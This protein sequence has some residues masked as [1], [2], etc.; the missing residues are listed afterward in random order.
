VDLG[1]RSLARLVAVGALCA[2][3]ATASAQPAPSPTPAAGAP[4]TVDGYCYW[5]EGVAASA[6]D[7]LYAPS[8][9]GSVGYVK[10][11]NLATGSDAVDAGVRVQAGLQYKLSGIYEASLT[12]DRA[13]HDC[14]RHKALDRVQGETTYRALEARVRTLDAALPEADKIL[15]Q[16]AGDVEGRRATAQDLVA[17]RLRV[18]ELR[19]LAGD[20]RRAI[21]ALPAPNP[22]NGKLGGALGDYYTHD[23]EIEKAEG[24]LRMMQGIDV[25]VRVGYD[26]FLDRSDNSPIFGLLQ[27]SF[28]LGILAQGGANDRALA[29]RRYMVR[30]QHQVQLVDTTI[31]HLRELVD[32][33][34]KRVE[35]TQVLMNDLEKQMAVLDKIGGDDN[36]RY[37]QTVWFD[38][39]KVQADNAYYVAHVAVLKQV[40]GE[41]AP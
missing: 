28:N 29:G 41:V 30:E 19:G 12:R 17:M 16:I 37:R 20:A 22:N 11:P 24:T 23:E 6:S 27:V 2:S 36:R 34:S 7:V 14:M 35:E 38:Y 4:S 8:V 10:E 1:Y 18:N 21:D 9:F 33:E 3:S 15:T 39:V 13:H 40:I 32:S 31:K 5:V 25:S 26:Q